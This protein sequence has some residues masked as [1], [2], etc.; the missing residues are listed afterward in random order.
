MMR[1]GGSCPR[2]LPVAVAG[3]SSC[4]NNRATMFQMSIF[5]RTV[6]AKRWREGVQR[7]RNTRCPNSSSSSP[8]PT[9]CARQQQ[10]LC[11]GAA[12]QQS[13]WAP[14]REVPLPDASCPATGCETRD[15]NARKEIRWP[16]SFF[17]VAFLAPSGGSGGRHPE[18]VGASSLERVLMGSS[19]SREAQT[20]RR[21]LRDIAAPAVRQGGVDGGVGA[22]RVTQQRLCR[23]PFLLCTSAA[24]PQAIHRRVRWET[25]Q[26]KECALMSPRAA[27][28]RLG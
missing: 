1:P 14:T 20:P 28:Q 12:H 17:V 10:L 19:D 9:P 15:G 27:L 3:S 5:C 18:R 4:R 7:P 24:A 21:K 13:P 26:A 2:H 25:G 16:F 6:F 8:A 23:A 22:A 11:R